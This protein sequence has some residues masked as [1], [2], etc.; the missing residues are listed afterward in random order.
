MSAACSI[1]HSV[2]S[3]VTHNGS[4]NQEKVPS[5]ALCT[6]CKMLQMTAEDQSVCW[7]LYVILRA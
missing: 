4:T 6:A 2:R 3:K 1:L 5:A 7:F